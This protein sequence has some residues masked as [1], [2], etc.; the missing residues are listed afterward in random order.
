M[1]AKMLH[2][3]D[4]KAVL[5]KVDAT[6]NQALAKGHGVKGF[7]TMLLFVDSSDGEKYTGAR[8]ALS[9]AN[10][11]HNAAGEEE[12]EDDGTDEEEDLN[13]HELT[14]DNAEDFTEHPIQKQLLV[15]ADFSDSNPQQKEEIMDAM[16]DTAQTMEGT[17]LVLYLDSTKKENTPIVRQVGDANSLRDCPLMRMA[18]FKGGFKV[19][20]PKVK[21]T[22]NERYPLTSPGMIKMIGDWSA[23]KMK[24][25][26]KSQRLPKPARVPQKSTQVVGLNFNIFVDD[27]E[28]DVLA[29]I[30]M[31]DC[32]F[33]KAFREHFDKAANTLATK[34]MKFAHI[35]GPE[36]DFDHEGIDYKGYPHV[37]L[38]PKGDK[39][40]PIQFEETHGD[41]A[42]DALAEFLLVYADV[43]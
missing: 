29:F 26:M 10:F 5:A 23:N 6:K 33:C 8:D 4:S 22:K 11:M 15:C 35:N 9:I 19:W 42:Y 36:N 18:T 27:P 13:V 25:Q 14:W 30:W 31:R 37:L 16:Y 32:A 38:F 3:S 39:N 20:M 17:V 12:E 24:R 41:E 43:E 7:P 34:S 28:A 21:D 1:A 2:F 40:H